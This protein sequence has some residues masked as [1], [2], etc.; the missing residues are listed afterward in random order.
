MTFVHVG[1][2]F[3]EY[4]F[5]VIFVDGIVRQMNKVVFHVVFLCFYIRFSCKS[6]QTLFVQVN[7]DGVMTIN[8]NVQSEVKLEILN[9]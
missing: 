6:C 9:E 2:I 1:L 7:P 5:F 4:K 3:V 8:Q